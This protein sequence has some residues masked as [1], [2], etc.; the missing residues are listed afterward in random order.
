VLICDDVSCSSPVAVNMGD[1]P[2]A[3][4]VV[5]QVKRR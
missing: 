5:P 3:G 1:D 4:T 2:A